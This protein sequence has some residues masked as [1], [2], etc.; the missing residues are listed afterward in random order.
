MDINFNPTQKQSTIHT[1]FFLD[2]TDSTQNQALFQ[3]QPT[4]QNIMQPQPQQHQY[5]FPQMYT[6]QQLQQQ[7]QLQHIHQI[8]SQQMNSNP[9]L[10]QQQ[11]LRQHQPQFRPQQQLAP[12]LLQ[13]QHAQFRNQQHLGPRHLQ[14]QQLP[15]QQ[16]Q[17][18]LLQQH[19]S[20]QQQQQQQLQQQQQKQQ[21]QQQQQQ[22]QQQQQQQK[23]QQQLQQQQ[24]PLQQTYQQN[25]SIV[26]TV[27]NRGGLTNMGAYNTQSASSPARPGIPQP[28][29]QPQQPQIVQPELNMIQTQIQMIYNRP[30]LNQTQPQQMPNLKPQVRPA[31]PPRML[32][33]P[34]IAY[35]SHT[36]PNPGKLIFYQHIFSVS[37][38]LVW[39]DK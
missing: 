8:N 25:S 27:G 15:I 26:S 2:W 12:Q 23:Q 5:Q 21:Q 3:T 24:P 31:H 9:V 16:Q 13:Q 32:G 1:V 14:L 33:P 20:Q 30:H 36:F 18:Q 34:L 6:Q 37:K 11:Y 28:H 17:Q 10:K 22:E 4:Q 38:I 29:F 35:T 39:C 19:L 7:L